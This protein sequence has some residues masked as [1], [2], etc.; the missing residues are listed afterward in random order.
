MKFK[1]HPVL[2]PLF[3]MLL[4]LDGLSA[5]AIIFSSLLFHEAGHII[6]AKYVGLRIKK[7]T[8]MP[9]GGE[10]VFWNKAQSTRK[11]RFIVALGGP[12]AT[13]FLLMVIIL[14]NIPDKEQIIRVQIALLV[15]NLLPVLPLDGGQA[16]V[17]YFEKKSSP[18]HVQTVFLIH[19]IMFFSLIIFFLLIELPNSI[20]YLLLAIFLLSQNISAF[21]FRKYERAFNEIKK[22]HLT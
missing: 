3:M 20:S 1:L 8:I 19:S 16:L 11:A 21:R 18:Y 4:F 13:L 5:Y 14:L 2:L 12:V 17:V 6:A 15:I 7:C 10:I 9:Y 22:N